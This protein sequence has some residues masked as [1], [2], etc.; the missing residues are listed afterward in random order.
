MFYLLVWLTDWSCRKLYF[1]LSWFFFKFN[2][3][4]MQ[5]HLLTD[6]QCDWPDTAVNRRRRSFCNK[7]EGYGSVCS[8]KDPA[9]LTF[10][11][12]QVS[13]ASSSFR[14]QF[15]MSHWSWCTVCSI[16]VGQFYLWA[17][18]HLFRFPTVRS[19]TFQ[20]WLLPATDLTTFTGAWFGYHF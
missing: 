16:S 8:C 1:S 4:R 2:P 9:A 11:P 20:L 6:G 3:T 12:P 18:F 5:Y 10:N 13:D 7:L 19:T 17:I 14:M 15:H